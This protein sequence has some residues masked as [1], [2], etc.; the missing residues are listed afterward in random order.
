MT[1]S[2]KLVVSG[3]EGDLELW[4][5]GQARRSWES[6]DECRSYFATDN[7]RN[8]KIR[9]E[10]LRTDVAT[11]A[12]LYAVRIG[13]IIATAES[14]LLKIPMGHLGCQAPRA[15][16]P[17]PHY[18]PAKS[19]WTV[20]SALYKAAIYTHRPTHKV[21]TFRVTH[22]FATTENRCKTLLIN[23]HV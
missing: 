21:S 7:S 20:T 4:A 16:I 17:H 1:E 3:G 19:T 22:S 5:L 11:S 12:S 15:S 10:L 13:A 2:S 18:D 6:L 14:G 9:V 23:R 8:L